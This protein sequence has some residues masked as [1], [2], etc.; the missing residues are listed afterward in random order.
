M[1][2]YDIFISYRRSSYDTANLVATRLK[3]AGYSVFFDMETLRSGKFNE[4]LFEVI[5]NCKDFVVVL[6]P[7]ALDRCVN[8]DDW[9][10]IEVCRA[11]AAGKNIVPVM[12]N[13]FVWPSPMPQGMEDLCEYQA[14]I[15]SSVEYFDLA[16]E[17]LQQRYLQSK[18]HFPVHKVAKIAGVLI[19][20]LL[21]VLTILWGIFMMLSQEVCK[22]Y[23]TIV[24]NHASSVHV[25]AEQNNNLNRYWDVFMDELARENNPQKIEVLKNDMLEYVDLVEKN[26]KSAW[27]ND[28]TEMVI[29]DYDTFLLSFHGINVEELKMTP[30]FAATYFKE[31]LS[32][33]DIVRNAVFDSQSINLEF[34][35][36]LFDVSVHSCNSFYAGILSVLSPFP[37]KAK[38][39]IEETRKQWTYFDKYALDADQKY[40][41]DIV[42]AE[43]QKA[44]ILMSEYRTMLNKTN[45][46]LDDLEIKAEQLEQDVDEKL[47]TLEDIVE[48]DEQTKEV[49]AKIETERVEAYNI[50]K[51]RCMFNEQDNQWEK[52]GKVRLWGSLLS[53]VA[54]QDKALLAD[55]VVL[56][57]TVT[58]QSLFSE[59]SKMLT[60][61][62]TAYPNSHG[63]V[64]TARAFY[65]E[66]A[67][68]KRSYSGVLVF[69]F[70]ENVNHPALRVGDIIVEYAGSP[71]K[72][73]ND[74]KKNYKKYGEAE[75]KFLRFSN[76]QFKE[77]KW[78]W[79]ENGDVG[80]LDLVQ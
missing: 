16:M 3:N 56:S 64:S 31:Y 65:Q 55:N 15:A 53:F 1:K 11:M 76:G 6:P 27:V 50:Y 43:G 30:L 20:T 60:N 34:V 62:Q 49:I 35:N 23:A 21:V 61:Y 80:L 79:K 39:T 52:W 58:A 32:Q 63:Y 71:V 26:I 28:T 38:D 77:K 29:S 42:L 41:E 9:V 8:E 19:A 44:E 24:G 4:Q 10:R 48:I 51:K 36:V 54:E 13:G 73:V 45:A 67:L 74:I 68:C 66:V 17:R 14:L 25:I 57:T 37:D 75:V 5:D 72:T 40:Y 78:D 2:Q 70:K 22:Q 59:M 46:E 12:L 7:N 18:R 33:L 69:A 47:G